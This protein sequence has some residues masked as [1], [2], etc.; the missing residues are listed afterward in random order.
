MKYYR[1]QA[2]EWIKPVRRGYKMACC[3]CG[4]V[5]RLDFKTEGKTK[6]KIYFRVYRDNR[7]TALVRRWSKP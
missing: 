4:L 5:H 7:A 2:G 6:R 3:D 1:P